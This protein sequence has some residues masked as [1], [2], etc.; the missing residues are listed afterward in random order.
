MKPILLMMAALSLTATFAC[1]T[2]RVLE[3]LEEQT[4]RAAAML[5]RDIG[6]RPQ[7]TGNVYDGKLAMVNVVFESQSVSEMRVVELR[8]KVDRV[9]AEILSEKPQQVLISVRFR[10]SEPPR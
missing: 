10:S 3:N 6:V 5:E 7:I 1:T 8:S 2:P 9:L 4:N